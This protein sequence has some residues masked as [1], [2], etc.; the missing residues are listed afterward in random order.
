[1]TGIS[2]Y[3][4]ASF[5]DV[6]SLS[7]SASLRIIKATITTEAVASVRRIIYIAQLI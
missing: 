4:T 1:M 7:N 2:N 3:S 5:I 6:L